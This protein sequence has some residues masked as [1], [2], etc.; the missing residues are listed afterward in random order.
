MI[1]NTVFGALNALTVSERPL[2]FEKYLST[3]ARTLLIYPDERVDFEAVMIAE[4]GTI[5]LSPIETVIVLSHYFSVKGMP[6]SSLRISVAGELTDVPVDAALVGTERVYPIKC[7]QI[8]TKTVVFS[9]GMEHTLYTEGGKNR[10]RIVEAPSETDFSPEL[11][12]RLS[13][14]SGLPD[15]VRS[16]AFRRA[17]DTYR[18]ASTDRHLTLDSVAPLAGYLFRQGIRGRIEVV[19]RGIT[20]KFT[21]GMQGEC[22]CIFGSDLFSSAP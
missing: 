6:T 5:L 10:A 14:V 4:D 18:M 20:V 11:L 21:L 22:V 3:G 2:S 19:C 16:V 17:A 7:K 8:Y 12:R 1:F 15:T 13:V 9:A